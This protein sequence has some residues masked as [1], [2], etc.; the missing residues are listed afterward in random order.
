MAI[1]WLNDAERAELIAK[2]RDAG[3]DALDLR[4]QLFD[5]IHRGWFGTLP[6]LNQPTFQLS[7]DLMK[8]NVEGTLIDG[9]VPI[10]LYL[11]NAAR[12]SADG[13]HAETAALIR[14][15]R[16]RVGKGASGA[17]KPKLAPPASQQEVAIGVAEF[18]PVG[19]LA[20]GARSAQA[21]GK[22]ESQ[23]VFDGKPQWLAQDQPLLGTGTGWL[24]A[25]GLLMTCH[26]VIAARGD[27]DPPLEAG[28]WDAQAM[29][30][31]VRFDYDLLSVPGKLVNVTEVL[32]KDE[33]LD[34]VL[35]RLATADGERGWLE[36]NQVIPYKSAANIIQHP[37]GRPKEVVVRNNQV[38]KREG[39]T[40]QYFSDTEPGS[41]GSPVCDDKWRVLALHTAHAKAPAGL[42]YQ[43]KRAF[44]V[45][46]GTV[47]QDIWNH[48]AD[49]TRAQVLQA[50]GA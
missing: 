18:L 47:M 42:E 4:P 14:G 36:R 37:D 26:H 35:L 27:A 28:D 33:K 24:L 1:Q 7:G 13:G 43:G 3:L 31:R 49:A 50:R 16:D 32:A 9:T 5:Q 15:L 20:S 19:Y 23:K 10:V 6:Q 46:E 2:M 45:N 17:P 30:T 48:L 8:L 39:S 12:L 21:V 38:H 22:V 25:P 40:V 29:R 11:G 41:S 34:Y 44:Y